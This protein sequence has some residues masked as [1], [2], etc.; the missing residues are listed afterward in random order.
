MQ[1]QTVGHF[2]VLGL[3]LSTPIPA[4]S[5]GLFIDSVFYMNIDF[6]KSIR[7]DFATFFRPSLSIILCILKYN[8]AN[9]L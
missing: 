4:K 5:K 1:Y 6:I 7:S 3:Q 8:D 9:L 2:H